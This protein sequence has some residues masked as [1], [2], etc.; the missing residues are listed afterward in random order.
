LI[1]KLQLTNYRAAHLFGMKPIKAVAEARVLSALAA[2][3]KA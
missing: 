2:P 1:R 3:E